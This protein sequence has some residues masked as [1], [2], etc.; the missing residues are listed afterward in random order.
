M[1][2]KVVVVAGWTKH[3]NMLRPTPWKLK[4]TIHMLDTMKL[5]KPTDQDK[6]NSADTQMSQ[7]TTHK[8]SSLLSNSNQS[9]LPLKLINMSSKDTEVESLTLDVEPTLTMVLP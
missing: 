2:T 6:S 5:A 7:S 1:E 8:L 4:T 9:V 3:S